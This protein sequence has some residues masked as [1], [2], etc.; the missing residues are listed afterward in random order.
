MYPRVCT[1]LSEDE[2]AALL[3][4]AESVRPDWRR[5]PADRNTVDDTHRFADEHLRG[6]WQGHIS[7]EVRRCFLLICLWLDDVLKP[8]D[9]EALR[10]LVSDIRTST[11]DRPSSYWEELRSRVEDMYP[12][13]SRPDRE[14]LIAALNLYVLIGP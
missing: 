12:D 9:H 8:Q 4:I 3:S 10:A 13:R 1:S 5:A 6:R 7:A 2:E 11:R 14:R